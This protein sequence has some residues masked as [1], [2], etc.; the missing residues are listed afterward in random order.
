M[1]T[2][3]Q[4]LSAGHALWKLVDRWLAGP[5]PK[6]TEG[7]REL[8]VATRHYPGEVHLRSL[9]EREGLE[10]RGCQHERGERLDRYP[11]FACVDCRRVV[12]AMKVR[13]KP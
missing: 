8:R 5:W 10:L 6:A 12:D 4:R 11:L 1:T 7:R 3:E 2:H 13:W 9:L